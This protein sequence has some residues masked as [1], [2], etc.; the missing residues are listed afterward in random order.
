MPPLA[1]SRL[2]RTVVSA[3][4]FQLYTSLSSRFSNG[5]LWGPQQVREVPGSG[6]A[7]SHQQDDS[8]FM[9]EPAT[10]DSRAENGPQ[11]SWSW[12]PLTQSLNHK[13][14]SLLLHC[15]FATVMHFKVNM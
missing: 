4:A 15:S 2:G 13:M 8:G 6:C 14:I 10:P 1:P 3:I 7:C 5:V 11:A 9:P 12:D